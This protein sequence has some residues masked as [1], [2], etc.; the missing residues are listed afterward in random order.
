MNII[1]GFT[2]ALIHNNSWRKKSSGLDY[3]QSSELTLFMSPSS[4]SLT[5][6]ISYNMIPLWLPRVY[7][8]WTENHLLST[9]ADRGCSH[10]SFLLLLSLWYYGFLKIN[11][12]CISERNWWLNKACIFQFC[13]MHNYYLDMDKFTGIFH[14]ADDFY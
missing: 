5:N 7:L 10:S 14:Y 8:R 11:P 3:F 13:K 12:T 9:D 6:S 1:F 4:S 2:V